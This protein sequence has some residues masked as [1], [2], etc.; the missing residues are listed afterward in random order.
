M[1]I[2]TCRMFPSIETLILMTS[3]VVALKLKPVS[4]SLLLERGL[5][6]SKGLVLGMHLF[7]DLRP[8]MVP[9]EHAGFTI[10]P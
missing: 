9:L 3:P 7:G 1:N 4:V 8:N 5:N 10:L 6:F 2:Y